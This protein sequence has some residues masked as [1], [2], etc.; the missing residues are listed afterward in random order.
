M[1]T[2]TPAWS[3]SPTTHPEPPAAAQPAASATSTAGSCAN[4]I[5]T[6]RLGGATPASD[7]CSRPE[8]LTAP[9]IRTWR[10]GRRI[11]ERRWAGTSNEKSESRSQE[12]DAGDETE[13][14]HADGE[15]AGRTAV[16]TRPR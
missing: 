7:P 3:P 12:Q 14:E 13:R 10:T 11:H 4:C 16:E 8:S 5:P 1:T 15:E 2:R 6:G 9:W